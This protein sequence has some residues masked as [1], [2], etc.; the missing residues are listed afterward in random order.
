MLYLVCCSITSESQKLLGKLER[1]DKRRMA[2]GKAGADAELDWLSINGFD[3]LVEA[4]I[5]RDSKTEVRRLH[6]LRDACQ[7]LI[8][9]IQ[10]IDAVFTAEWFL[11]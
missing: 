9:C 3:A 11:V 7:L 1:K 4:E 2:K 10:R 5:M 6:V 8:P